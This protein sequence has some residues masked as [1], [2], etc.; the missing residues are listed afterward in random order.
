[1]A[2]GFYGSSDDWD[3]ISQPL[4]LIDPKLER[5][6]RDKGLELKRNTK[7]WP[8][9]EFRW[10]DGLGRLIQIFL[11]SEEHLT[12]TMWICADEERSGKRYWR[13]KRLAKAVKIEKLDDALEELLNAGWE[14][15]TNWVSGD[16]YSAT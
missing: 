6:A 4:L 1:M 11:E 10:R 12:W 16:L 13:T 8:D 15:V 9:R 5:F 3:R 7:N 2:N 14:D